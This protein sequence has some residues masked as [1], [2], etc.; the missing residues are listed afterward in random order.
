MANLLHHYIRL[1]THIGRAG[2]VV[3]A[4]L[5]GHLM[6]LALLFVYSA[7]RGV[8]LAL[9]EGIRPHVVAFGSACGF[10]FFG[11]LRQKLGL[12]PEA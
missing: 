7:L 3:L 5:T 6:L 4:L 1:A 2:A 10:A 8:G 9:W 12:P 11:R